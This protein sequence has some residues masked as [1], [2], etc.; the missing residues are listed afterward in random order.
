M[1]KAAATKTKVLYA[2]GGALLLGGV[3]AA[4]AKALS[5]QMV[6]LPPQPKDNSIWI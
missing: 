5:P 4:I 1:R 3:A 2:V 6:Q